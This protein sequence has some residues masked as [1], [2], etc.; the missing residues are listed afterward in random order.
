M[1]AGWGSRGRGESMATA[2]L[3]SEI[4]KRRF[5]IYRAE[6]TVR[7]TVKAIY[8]SEYTG[9][10]LTELKR[11]L[12]AEKAVLAQLEQLRETKGPVVPG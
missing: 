2:E 3:D 10:A 7:E 4:Q 1:R 12:I 5:A 8:R 11:A 9:R 6:R